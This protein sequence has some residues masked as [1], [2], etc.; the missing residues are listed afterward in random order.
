M[1]TTELLLLY[2][3]LI[4]LASLAGGWIPLMVRLTHTHLEIAS[5]FISGLMLGVGLL[6]LLPH[7][8]FEIGSIDRA[9][10]WLLAGFLFT[11]LIQRFF[12]HHMHDLP[13]ESQEKASG[14]PQVSSHKHTS[15]ND[16]SHQGHDQGASQ[17]I[18][19]PYIERAIGKR[20]SWLG[21]GM[22]LALHTLI[23]G[24][25]LAASIQTE[26]QHSAGIRWAGLGTFLVILLHKPFDAWTIGTLM[27]TGGW[28]KGQR[29]FVNAIFA[30]IIPLGVILFLAGFHQAS[31]GNHQILGYALAFAAGTFLCIASIDLLPELQFHKHD[32]F[33]LTFALVLGLG[34]AVL[35]GKFESS[36]H[37]HFHE[38][39]LEVHDHAH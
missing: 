9:M 4:L 38:E 14:D 2:C 32:R 36:G 13:M 1:T 39:S 19:E 21:A 3:T 24:M 35:I 28:T 15:C 37:D 30:L 22:G 31:G 7:A 29:H 34:L 27:S 20:W 23:N 18:V 16:P 8:W 25:V 26:M 12:H 5:S 11:F 17:T 33:K 10:Q 6:H